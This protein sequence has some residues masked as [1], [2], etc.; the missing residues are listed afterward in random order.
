MHA[1][2]ALAREPVLER[3][4]RLAHERRALGG[5]DVGGVRPRLHVDDVA[6]GDEGL[7]PVALDHDARDL[8]AVPSGVALGECRLHAGEG[9][10]E[11]LALDGLEH[12]VD[13]VEVEGVRGEL[14]VG[15]HE[16]DHGRVPEVFQGL[17]KLHAARARHRDVEEDDVRLVLD[18]RG[19]CLRHAARLAYLVATPV[20][21]EQVAQLGPDGRLVIDDENVPHSQ[22]PPSASRAV[23]REARLL[24]SFRRPGST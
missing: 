3:E 19:H 6:H 15:G 5:H 14:G 9:A 20:T 1:K 16:D 4:D 18:G 21:L 8:G 7:S 17:R 12:V 10:L 22:P 11:A 2:E 24:P 23:R 13:R